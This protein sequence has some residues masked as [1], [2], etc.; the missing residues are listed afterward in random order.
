[1][2]DLGQKRTCAVQT[3]TSAKGTNGGLTIRLT[4]L[5]RQKIYQSAASV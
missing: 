1:M 5:H 4:D 2:S 3:P